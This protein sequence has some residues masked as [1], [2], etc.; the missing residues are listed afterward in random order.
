[1]GGLGFVVDGKA[2]LILAI[3][4]SGFRNLETVP[5]RRLTGYLRSMMKHRPGSLAPSPS[6]LTAVFINEPRLD[7]P[8]RLT[9]VEESSS[10]PLEKSLGFRD[11]PRR[12]LG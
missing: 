10:P 3:Q 8:P 9:G 6:S 5:R 4:P 11:A 12:F 7:T 1:M 2:S